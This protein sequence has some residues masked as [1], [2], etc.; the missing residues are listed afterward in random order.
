M[1]IKYLAVVLCVLSIGI[2]PGVAS[3]EEPPAP[4]SADSVSKA[5]E[6]FY[7]ALNQMF[8]GELAPM[9]AVWSH[10]DDVV[11]VG[12][13]GGMHTG[14]ANILPIWK[15]QA[16]LKL[17]GEIKIKNMHV[18]NGEDIAVVTNY[19]VG[20]NTINGEVQKVE[21]RAT[22][23]FRKE[24]GEWKMIGHHTDLLPWLVKK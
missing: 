9:E 19:E 24:D 10:K 16:D 12:P 3:A 23:I 4:V 14:W 17:G 8:V 2:T 7:A 22:N 21:L 18:I 20:E 15:E 1:R 6:A 11:Y 5:T 13:S